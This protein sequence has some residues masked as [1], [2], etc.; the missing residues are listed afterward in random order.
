MFESIELGKE[1]YKICHDDD[2]TR[3]IEKSKKVDDRKNKK[4]MKV[5]IRFTNDKDN[6]KEL[7]DMLKVMYINEKI[8]KCV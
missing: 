2:G 8:G 7:V 6:T 4:G 5:E 1:T 3:Y